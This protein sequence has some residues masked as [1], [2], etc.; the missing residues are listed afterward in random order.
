MRK[1]D[2]RSDDLA[3]VSD[4]VLEELTRRVQDIDNSYRAVAEKMGQLYMRA[5]THHVAS[6]TESLDRPMRNASDNEQTF[7]AILEDL[8]MYATRRTPRGE[9]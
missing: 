8:R 3:A 6:L 9:A 5:D 7:A 4:D 1:K 2:R